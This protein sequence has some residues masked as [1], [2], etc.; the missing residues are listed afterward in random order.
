M[1]T[2]DYKQMGELEGF[3]QNSWNQTLV[4]KLNQMSSNIEKP[5]EVVVHQNLKP[6]I[7]SLMVTNGYKFR[8]SNDGKN[9]IRIGDS[10]LEVLNYE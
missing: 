4:T 2:W 3:L 8:F 10:Y 9:R 6:I 5:V 1:E 7:K